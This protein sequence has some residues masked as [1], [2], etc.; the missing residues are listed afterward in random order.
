MIGNEKRKDIDRRSTSIKKRIFVG[1]FE[2]TVYQGQDCTRVWASAIVEMGSEDVTILGSIDD[3]FEYLENIGSDVLIYYHNLKF[4]GEFWL[5]H[6]MIDRGFKQALQMITTDESTEAHFLKTKKEMPMNSFSYSISDMGAW[7]NILIKTP[8]NMIEIRDSLKLLPFSVRAIGEGFKT[9]HRKLSMKYEGLRYPGC[10]ISD[11]EKEYIKNDVLVVKESLEFMYA[12]DH[13]KLTIGACCLTEFKNILGKYDYQTFFPDLYQIEINEER[14]GSP[15]IGEYIRKSY[16][17]G[18]CYVVKGKEGKVFQKGLTADVNSLYPSVMHSISGNAY[19]VGKPSLW[20]GNFIPEIA[21]DKY[22]F[23]RF[24]CRFYL[25]SE[26]LPFVQLKNSFRYRSTEMLETSDYYNRKDGKYYRQYYDA[27]DGHLKSTDVT[28]TMTCTDYIRFREFYDVEDFVILD[29]CWF[30]SIVG[31]FDDYIDKYRK[32]KM[33]SKGAMRQLAKLF[34]NNLYG[35]LATSTN[36]SF[37]VGYQKEDDSLGYTIYHEF[38]K[39]PGFIACG[40]A[41]TSYARDFTIR[42]AQA[43]FYGVDKPGFIYADTDSIHCDL[44]VEDLK[45]IDIDANEFLCWKIEST[46]DHAKFIRQKTY[47]E[48]VIEEDLKPVEKPYYSVKCAG[49]PDRCKKLFLLSMGEE[50]KEDDS[51]S[52]NDLDEEEKAFLEI[53][54]TFDDFKEGLEVPGKLMPTHIPGGVLL[55]KTT[56]KIRYLF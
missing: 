15:N 23:I 49:M 40:S 12:N 3:T 34:L 29:G 10:Y 37:K 38:E 43:N 48:H 8:K 27:K 4:D 11:D 22:Y 31:I 7:Y 9:K 30:Y 6:L 50:V 18:W 33:E 47:A 5:Y 54:R 26:K 42:K 36:S 17:G 55:Q 41:V 13:K 14:Y 16:H 2:T 20:H 21:K 1:D 45:G 46:W 53:K 25:K 24:R 19:P 44:A 52:I 28:M 51:F 56:Y 35:K 32:I 39:K